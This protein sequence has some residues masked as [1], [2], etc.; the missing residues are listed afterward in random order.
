MNDDLQPLK[1]R[2]RWLNRSILVLGILILL[3]LIVWAVVGLRKPTPGAESTV[4]HPA[5]SASNRAAR[6][7]SA[8]AAAA[9]KPA[10]STAQ[11]ERAAAAAMD[12]LSAASAPKTAAETTSQPAGVTSAAAPA[13]VA[14]APTPAPAAVV[15]TASSAVAAVAPSK[16]VAK[17]ESAQHKR[18]QHK[19]AVQARIEPARA[20]AA[21]AKPKRV[22]AV[23]VCRTAGW[24]VQVGAFGKQQS[25]DRLAS[26]LHRA[27]Y[28]Q[29][30]VAAQQVRG[31]HLF[32]VG[33]YKNAASARDAKAP[34]HKLT[35]AE[36]ILR[37]LG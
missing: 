19:P 23:G 24:Y 26:K 16:P 25:I 11:Q 32:Y 17:P 37:K 22:G 33:P 5:S 9:P 35:G 4:I 2:L 28:T 12:A 3:G 29:V 15:E 30:C 1:N 31:L 14:S 34:L 27:G 7:A 21:A 18:A 13:E 8:V 10:M 20:A 36:G 6:A